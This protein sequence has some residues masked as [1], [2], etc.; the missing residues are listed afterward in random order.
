MKVRRK[1]PDTGEY[2]RIE[3]TPW[4]AL[5]FAIFRGAT[6]DQ[7][8]MV[9]IFGWRGLLA[10]T[11]VAFWSWSLGLFPPP[12]ALASDNDALKARVTNLDI[13]ALEDSLIETRRVQCTATNKGFATKR[14]RELKLEYQKLVGFIWDEPRCDEI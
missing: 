8:G 5:R 3:V 13:R 2:R 9:I 1:D 14:L 10:S 7:I 12:Y 4:D 6:N 11:A